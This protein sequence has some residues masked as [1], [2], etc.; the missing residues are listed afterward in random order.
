MG[1]PN[2]L[3]I[4]RIDND[5]DY[6]PENCLWATMKTVNRRKTGV[7]PNPNSMRQKCLKAGLPYLLVY[8]RMKRG[9]WSEEKA[10]STP[11]QRRGRQVGF[12]PSEHRDK[13]WKI[14]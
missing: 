13:L 7:A 3:T 8:F 14:S 2:G 5:G 6:C 1:E 4:D 11:I 9:G 10:L 12:R